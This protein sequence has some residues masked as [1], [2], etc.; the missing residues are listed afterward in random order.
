M[1]IGQT[2]QP[3]R[4]R[5]VRRAIG[6]AWWPARRPGPGPAYSGLAARNIGGHT[7]LCGG[8]PGGPYQYNFQRELLMSLE[9]TVLTDQQVGELVEFGERHG[10]TIKVETNESDTQGS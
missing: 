8:P 1:Q 6:P 4:V 7:A 10:L 2:M 3:G 9:A 5:P